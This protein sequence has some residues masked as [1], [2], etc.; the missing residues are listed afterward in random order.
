M[1]KALT[2]IGDKGKHFR[3]FFITVD[4]ERDTAAMLKDYL[5][6]FDPRIEALVPTPG[7]LTKVAK[8]F[9]AI[10]EKV[11]GSDGEYTMNHTATV[12]LMNRDGK[13]AST[14]SYDETPEN[15]IAKLNHLLAGE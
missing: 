4:P 10:Y 15:R 12:Y 14:I 7:E 1:T 5:S 13:L 6:N 3:L 9:R 11:P 2:A 8:E